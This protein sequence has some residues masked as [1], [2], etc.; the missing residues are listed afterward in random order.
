M[1]QLLPFPVSLFVYSYSYYYSALQST[2]LF[3]TGSWKA[4]RRG[5]TGNMESL[6]VFFLAVRAARCVHITRRLGPGQTLHAR[7]QQA[8]IKAEPD[9]GTSTLCT[10]EIEARSASVHIF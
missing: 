2:L 4:S 1:T 7:D 6:V 10:G 8:E 3:D 9:G 5:P